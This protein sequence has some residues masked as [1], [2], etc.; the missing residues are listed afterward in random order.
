MGGSPSTAT[1]WSHTSVTW[2]EIRESSRLFAAGYILCFLKTERGR[3]L[4]ENN[5]GRERGAQADCPCRCRSGGPG[6]GRRLVEL[7]RA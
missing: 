2:D 1:T 4:D 7:L 5:D 3:P 6:Y